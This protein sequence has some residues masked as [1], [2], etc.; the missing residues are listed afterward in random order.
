M[1]IFR[2]GERSNSLPALSALISIHALFPI[3]CR[4]NRLLSSTVCSLHPGTSDKSYRN[5]LNSPSFLGQYAP[6][7]KC[8]LFLPARKAIHTAWWK[9]YFIFSVWDWSV[10]FL[11]LFRCRDS[12]NK[13]FARMVYATWNY[14][15]CLLPA[16]PAP[17]GGT[18]VIQSDKY[19]YCHFPDSII[20]QYVFSEFEGIDR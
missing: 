19:R 12:H 4:Q 11:L 2:D 20:P 8:S 1:R 13:W 16:P 18:A 3:C 10:L 5:T 7:R 9:Y 6:T 14:R 17:P 15:P